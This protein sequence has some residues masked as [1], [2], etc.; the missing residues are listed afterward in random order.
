LYSVWGEE[1]EEVEKIKK[2]KVA[3]LAFASFMMLGLIALQV[4]AAS[5]PLTLTSPNSLSTRPQFGTKVSVDAKYVV[6]GAP[7][8]TYGSTN[9]N[10]V[11]Y[12]FD[13][14]SGNLISTLSSPNPQTYSF[15]GHSVSVN[16]RYTVVGAPSETV[17]SI[18]GAGR[19]YIF[20]T[21]SGE[22]VYTL[23]SPNPQAFGKFG[24]SVSTSG[25]YVV[26]GATYDT[27]GSTSFSGVAYVFDISSGML[28]NTLAS[29]NPQ[30][31][32]EFGFSVSVSGRYVAVGADFDAPLSGGKTY[33]FDAISGTL[34]STL[35]SP[36]AQNLGRFGWST[37]VFGK[38]VTVGAPYETSSS[39]S[40]AGRAYV[41]DATSGALVSTLTSP[42]PATEGNFGSSVATNG[43]YAIAG[44]PY[45]T[46]HVYIF[47]A[48]SG[49]LAETLASPNSQ[50]GGNFGC[51]ISSSGRYIVI[52]AVG[53]TVHT[54]DYEGRAYVFV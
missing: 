47:E 54:W 37:S 21:T 52:G 34:I 49:T 51:S 43:K 27:S 40:D 31:Y 50:A 42:N 24:D 35:T 3:I 5:Y 1:G 15:F 16:G 25:R 13:A 29:P 33:V 11:A 7:Y 9:I 53:E 23:T 41:F 18:G 6:V 19:A 30:A 28:I 22:L 46:G 10:G 26:V 48:K 36:N 44:E 8:D 20:D 39:L 32:G 4:E 38:Y 17:N 12:V 45:D 2:Q 14:I